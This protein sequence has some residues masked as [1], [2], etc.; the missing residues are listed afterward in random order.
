M[1]FIKDNTSNN[2]E[3]S[4]I[5][6]KQRL[7][8]LEND[9]FRYGRKTWNNKM[10]KKVLKSCKEAYGKQETENTRGYK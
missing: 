6:L 3:G 7:K 8:Q 10:V 1:K 9:F 2:D 5:K 4:T